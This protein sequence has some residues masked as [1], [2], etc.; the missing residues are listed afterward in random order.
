MDGEE[1]RDPSNRNPGLR[2]RLIRKA[3][4]M[5]LRTILAAAALV[6]PLAAFHANA[7]E[8]GPRIEHA[9]ARATP[10]A[11]KVG[12][13]YLTV[14]APAADK[15]VGATSPVAGRVEF[16]THADENGVMTMREVAGGV[17]LPAG[18]TVEL[19]PGGVHLMLLDLKR[20]LKEGESFPLTLAFEKAGKREVTVQVEKVGAM[21]GRMGA[22]DGMAHHA[23]S[24][25]HHG[26]GG[27]SG[28]SG[29]P[30]S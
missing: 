11:A 21:G 6:L 29:R 19:N 30:G 3:E 15:L 4:F 28:P 9:W 10:G 2:A 13:A 22:M 12:A 8:D 27:A 20:P 1:R 24:M 14:R 7:A 18:R 5:I 16:H 25:H 26:G 23:D 17:D